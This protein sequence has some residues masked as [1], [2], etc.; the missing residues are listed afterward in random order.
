MSYSV[1]SCSTVLMC[2]GTSAQVDKKVAMMILKS[3]DHVSVWID[4]KCYNI[5][6]SISKN[7]K[8][9]SIHVLNST[10]YVCIHLLF[11]NIMRET[12]KVKYKSYLISHAV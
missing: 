10:K 6:I 11:K 9:L 1:S 12:L 2:V 4:G 8:E 7:S 3:E 5:F